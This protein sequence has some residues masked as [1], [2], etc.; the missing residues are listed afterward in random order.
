VGAVRPRSV[1]V[2]LTAARVNPD[3]MQLGPGT[4]IP[5]TPDRAALDAEV[6]RS[7]SYTLWLGGAFGRGVSVTVDGVPVGDAV[8][9]E[10]QHAGQF[11]S[12]GRVDL[13]RG[14]HLVGLRYPDEGLRP[15]DGDT[16]LEMGPLVLVPDEPEPFLL[17]V[18]SQDV[19]RLCRKSLDWAEV[20]VP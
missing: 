19:G 3:W 11:V 16:T 5:T 7:G 1:V 10:R 4:V 9:D 6:P 18:P 15:G 17:S 8:R 20:V 13:V 12:V 14:R 2:P